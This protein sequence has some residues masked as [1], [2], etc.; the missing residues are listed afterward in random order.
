M[1]IQI[2][3]DNT[4]AVAYIN[5]LGGTKSH[6]LRSLAAN[7]CGIGAFSVLYVEVTE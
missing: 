7:L 1:V 3:L 2:H 5:H 4:T 6:D